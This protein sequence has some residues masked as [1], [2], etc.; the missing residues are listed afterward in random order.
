MDIGKFIFN[1]LKDNATGVLVGEKIYPITIPQEIQMPAVSYQRVSMSPNY[2][3]SGTSVVDDYR[4]Q[5]DCYAAK[6]DEC[7]AL[8]QAVREDLEG[9][10]GNYEGTFINIITVESLTDGIVEK[11]DLFR[12]VID[13]EISY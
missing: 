4:Y 11:N 10:V 1:R 3:K 6:Y 5:I 13:F 9:F 12:K 2:C 7:E 8:L